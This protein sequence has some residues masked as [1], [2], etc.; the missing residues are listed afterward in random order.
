MTNVNNNDEMIGCT[1][2]DHLQRILA[3]FDFDFEMKDKE[4]E[5]EYEKE[6]E[7][8][9]VTNWP[10]THITIKFCICVVVAGSISSSKKNVLKL[11]MIFKKN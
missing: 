2:V 9:I 5:K 3:T 8:N 11:S 4:Q 10:Q 1:V 6:K 7:M